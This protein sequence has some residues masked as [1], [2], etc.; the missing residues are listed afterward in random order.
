MIRQGF[1]VIVA[2]ALAYGSPAQAARSHKLD[3]PAGRLGDAV[4]AL[5]QQAGAS[6]AVEDA[7]LWERRVPAIKATLTVPAALRRLIG[8]AHAEILPAGPGSWRIRRARLPRPT[9]R[10]TSRRHRRQPHRRPMSS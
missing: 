9:G 4:T 6:I 8:D 1:A 3:L 5:G 10:S 7:G 2:V